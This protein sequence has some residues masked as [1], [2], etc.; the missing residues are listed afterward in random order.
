MCAQK[1]TLVGLIYRTEPKTEKWKKEK[2]EKVKTD[3]LRSIGP[4]K[5]CVLV[6]SLDGDDSKVQPIAPLSCVCVV[7]CVVVSVRLSV[8]HT[9]VLYRNDWT[10]RAGFGHEETSFH[11]L[12]QCAIKKVGYL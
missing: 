9:P 8:C 5:S 6:R 4:G 3:M 12:L 2:K 10:E 7:S 1:L 11:G